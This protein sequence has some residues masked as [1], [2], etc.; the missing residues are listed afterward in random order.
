MNRR[1]LSTAM[2]V[3]SPLLLSQAVFA[4]PAAHPLSL[5]AMFSK[6][7]LVDFNLRNDTSAPLK[8]KA[9]DSA[10][11]IDAGKTLPLKLAAGTSV[12]VEEAT[13]DHPVGSVIALVSTQLSGATIS[14]K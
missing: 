2:L 11:T 10:I 1:V 5:H 3:V 13:T 7:K 9:G 8:L 6:G 14:I 4:A 12:T